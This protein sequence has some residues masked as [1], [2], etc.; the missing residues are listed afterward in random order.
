MTTTAT[1]PPIQKFLPLSLNL[2]DPA[3]VALLGNPRS[4]RG[5]LPRPW[6]WVTL[7][8]VCAARRGRTEVARVGGAQS[9]ASPVLSTVGGEQAGEGHGRDAGVQRLFSASSGHEELEHSLPTKVTLA[10]VMFPVMSA[11]VGCVH[12]A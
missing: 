9:G 5:S 10:N 4:H 8:Q 6:W 12:S 2:N 7:D 11:C 1:S 3:H